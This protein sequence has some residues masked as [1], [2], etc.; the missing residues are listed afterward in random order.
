MTCAGWRSPAFPTERPT[1]LTLA[2]ANGDLVEHVLAFSLGYYR[3]LP[4]IGKPRAWVSHGIHDQV[5]PVERCG[6][7]VV[8]QLRG[9]GYD[10]QYVEFDGTHVVTPDLVATAVTSWL[11]GD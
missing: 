5:L 2:L 1:P 8:A 3:P 10:V 9:Q 11:G 6:R 7:V 4:A